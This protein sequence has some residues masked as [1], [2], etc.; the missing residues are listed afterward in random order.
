V[1]GTVVLSWPVNPVRAVAA[2]SVP[3]PAGRT[4]FEIPIKAEHRQD[5]VRA[6]RGLPFRGPGAGHPWPCPLPAGWTPNFAERQPLVFI[7]VEPTVVAEVE[8]DA[9]LDGTFGHI[10]HRGRLVR[11]RLDLQ[12]AI[13]TTGH[14]ETQ[15]GRAVTNATGPLADAGHH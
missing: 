5:V 14:A 4:I 15:P 11:I 6:L 2:R 3:E 13:A 12:P 1:E 8:V 9:A 10:R 7:P